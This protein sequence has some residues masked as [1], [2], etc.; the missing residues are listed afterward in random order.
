MAG[1]HIQQGEVMPWTNTTGSDILSGA[2]VIVATQCCVALG[3][4]ADGE[5]GQLATC[6]V[7]DL[8][9]AAVDIAQGDVLYWDLNDDPVGGV[10]G[11]GAITNVAVG[12][13]DLIDNN[14]AGRA[15]A[16][17]LAA[18][19]VVQIKLGTV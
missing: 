1:N 18:A 17:A 11:S 3:D 7:F 5:V 6:E 13:V 16:P 8:P 19:A 14:V 12:A 10:V 9:K 2:V 4:I 15:F